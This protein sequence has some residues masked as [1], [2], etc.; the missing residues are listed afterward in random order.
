MSSF[1]SI[2]LIVAVFASVESSGVLPV[3]PAALV[4]PEQVGYA[5]AVPQNVPP[6]AAQINVESR[7][8]NTVL[9]AAAYAASPS[10]AAAPYVSAP[11]PYFPSPYAASYALPGPFASAAY[12]APYPYAA[13]PSLIRSPFGFAPTFVR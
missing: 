11:S 12:A 1:K 8:I 4:A 13:A 5:H 3:A 10:F 9:P 7:A 6:Y 2:A